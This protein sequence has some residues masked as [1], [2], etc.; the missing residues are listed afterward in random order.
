MGPRS[1]QSSQR[2]RTCLLLSLALHAALLSIVFEKQPP[3]GFS[4]SRILSLRLLS[5]P[6]HPS[7]DMHAREASPNPVM[8][9]TSGPVRPQRSTTEL[10]EVPTNTTQA[11]TVESEDEEPTDDPHLLPRILSSQFGVDSESD[12]EWLSR[13]NEAD[14]PDPDAFLYPEQR[15]MEMALSTPSIQLPFEDRRIYL[16]D[17]YSAGINGSIE[18]FWDRVTLPFGWTTKHGTHFECAWVLII[19][20]CAWGPNAMFQQKAKRR[21]KES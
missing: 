8:K 16:I 3:A 13:V 14:S 1:L 19:G 12:R 17:S 15:S 10:S 20:G 9:D 6:P 4:P 2:W 18:R 7:V 5:P 11:G 21:E